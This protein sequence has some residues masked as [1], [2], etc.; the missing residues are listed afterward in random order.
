MRQ[1]AGLSG[2]ELAR[3]SNVSAQY[4]TNCETG[5]RK[6]AGKI[7]PVR[8]SLDVLQRWC[9]I[10]GYSICLVKKIEKST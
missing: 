1:V 7:V 4:V 10:C 8:P 9:E 5:E 3:R 6:R 2:A